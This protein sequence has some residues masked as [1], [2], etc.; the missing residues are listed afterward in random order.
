MT[1]EEFKKRWESDEKGGGITNEDVANCYK[2]WELGGSP[3][4]K[5]INYVIWRVCDSANTNDKEQWRKR[6]LK[7]NK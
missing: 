1:R 7:E 5:K 6:Y 2:D 3:Y 4:I